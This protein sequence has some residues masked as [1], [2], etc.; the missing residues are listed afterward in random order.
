MIEVRSFLGLVGYC[1]CFIKGFY[2][3]T[4][5]IT[6]E[7]KN[8]SKFGWTEA[9]EEAFQT[10]KEKLT[11]TLILL[12]LLDSSKNYQAY[13]DASKNGLRYVLI[14]DI[15]LISYTFRQLKR[16]EMNYPTHEVELEVIIFALNMAA[17]LVWSQM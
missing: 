16:H 2:R 9:S 11:T 15:M 13:S 17:L 5:A 7:M 4:K 6:N 8:D 14:Q 10:L 1:R 3:I 12:A